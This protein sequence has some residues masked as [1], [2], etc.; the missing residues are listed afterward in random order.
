MSCCHNPKH[1]VESSNECV[2]P[3]H[4]ISSIPQNSPRRC[5]PRSGPGEWPPGWREPWRAG[6][7]RSAEPWSPDGLYSYDSAAA[8]RRRRES[9]PLPTG[10]AEQT[11]PRPAVLFLSRLSHF[12]WREPATLPMLSRL[13]NERTQAPLCS[14]QTNTR[15][16]CEA[17]SS[18]CCCCCWRQHHHLPPTTTYQPAQ[19]RVHHP[20][21]RRPPGPEEPRLC[22]MILIALY[23][24]PRRSS[25]RPSEPPP[26]KRPRGASPRPPPPALRTAA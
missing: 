9:A 1:T 16:L 23:L 13:N 12:G 4:P 25:P 14:V 8:G 26:P 21:A 17:N 24:L 18:T 3:A 15:G 11:Q 22:G 6:A 10:C 2:I 20:L 19:Q 5:C 7:P